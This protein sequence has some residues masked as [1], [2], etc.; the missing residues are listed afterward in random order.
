M[1]LSPGCLDDE[2]E[3]MLESAL[4]VR[5]A[6]FRSLLGGRPASFDEIAT[7]AGVSLGSARRAARDVA[8]VGMA[9]IDEETVVGMDGLTTRLTSHRITLDGVDLWTWCAYDIVGIAAALGSDATGTTICGECGREIEVEIRRGDP[10]GDFVGWLP[11]EACS[12][13]MA[14]FCPNALFFCSHEHLEAWRLRT[15]AGRGEALDPQALA[16]RGREEWRQLVA[17]LPR[18]RPPRTSRSCS[19]V[20]DPARPSGV[21]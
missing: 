6:A 18:Y 4:P 16:E 9:E 2:R 11:A 5:R 3:A 10:D 14:E 12:N 13:V 21:E 20:G 8:T 15:D 1:S 17:R 7:E 19:F